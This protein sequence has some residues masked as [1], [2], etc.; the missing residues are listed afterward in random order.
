MEVGYVLE[1]TH[2]RQGLATEAAAACR[3]YAFDVIRVDRVIALVR[4]GNEPSAGVAGKIGLVLWKHTTRA[5]LDHF[6]FSMARPS[7]A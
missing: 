6:V 1:R 7:T 2:W 5:G 3:D 4:V